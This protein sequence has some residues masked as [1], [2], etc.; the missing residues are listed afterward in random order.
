MISIHR[1]GDAPSL[2]VAKQPP[3]LPLSVSSG[4]LPVACPLHGSLLSVAQ[5]PT[6]LGPAC[7]IRGYNAAALYD[8][9]LPDNPSGM[10]S[11]LLQLL[12]ERLKVLLA[13][14]VSAFDLGPHP[15]DEIHLLGIERALRHA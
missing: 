14:E 13:N 6:L 12:V 3:R 5:Q 10:I 15:H 11:Q 8:Q 2:Y 9:P 7:V 4:M 1:R